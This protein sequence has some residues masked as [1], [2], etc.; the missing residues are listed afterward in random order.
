MEPFFPASY[1]RRTKII[2]ALVTAFLVVIAIAVQSVFAAVLAIVVAA[3]SYA[4]SPRG[5]RLTAGA[6]LVKRPIGNVSIPLDG[7]RQARRA[8][9][10]DLAGSIRLWGSGG[11]FGYYGLFYTSGLGNSRWYVTNQANLVVLLGDR[12]AVLS[13]DDVDGFL[14]AVPALTSVS[15]VAL[16]AA[17]SAWPR[18]NRLGMLVGAGVAVLAAIIAGSALLYSPGPPSYT[19][20]PSNLAIHD[21]FYPVTLSASEVDAQHTRIVDIAMDRDWRPTLRTNG[22]ANTH[23]RAGW[24]RTANGR[25]VRMYRAGGTRLVLLAPRGQG[26]PVLLEVADPAA[27]LSQLHDAWR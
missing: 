20:T 5:Y 4:Y 11:M 27:F 22:F 8:E 12:P 17:G 9:P 10:G 24:F 2:S 7:I 23:Y 1:D 21:R 26:A 13:P 25:T 6:I 16:D 3:L 15:N 18:R 19:L 14:A